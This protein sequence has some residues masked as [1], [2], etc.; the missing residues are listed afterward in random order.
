MGEPFKKA[1][2][3]IADALNETALMEFDD[4]AVGRHAVY[5][6]WKRVFPGKPFP[7]EA[8]IL[9]TPYHKDPGV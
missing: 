4:L 8:D 6:L 3:L 7:P 9:R 1:M 2:L 5:E